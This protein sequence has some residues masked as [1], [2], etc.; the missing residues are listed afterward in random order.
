LPASYEAEYKEADV[1]FRKHV[2]IDINRTSAHLKDLAPGIF[3]IVNISTEKSGKIKKL[4]QE[5]GS[6]DVR[7]L[8]LEIQRG[9]FPPPPPAPVMKLS[10]QER[11]LKRKVVENKI[12]GRYG[13]AMITV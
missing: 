2:G 6:L 13:E 11:A 8:P 12:F 7:D 9:Y 4:V 1:R 5:T 3:S 10:K